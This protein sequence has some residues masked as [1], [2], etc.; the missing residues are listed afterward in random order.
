MKIYINDFTK[1]VKAE[2]LPVNTPTLD[3]TLET[4]S[5]ALLSTKK[6]LSASKIAPMQKVKVEF[7]NTTNDVAYFY[8]ISD[9][10]EIFSTNPVRYKHTISCI[11]NTRELSKHSVRNSVFTQPAY[12]YKKSMTPIIECSY[13]PDAQYPIAA[14]ELAT[15][16][17]AYVADKGTTLGITTREKVKKAYIEIDVQAA[18]RY[19]NNGIETKKW[20]YPTDLTDLNDELPQNLSQNSIYLNDD[21]TNTHVLITPADLGLS[22]WEFNKKIECPLVKEYIEDGK[23]D[24]YLS[25]AGVGQN[26]TI[27]FTGGNFASSGTVPLFIAVQMRI[28]VETY[29][30]DCYNILNLLIER[31]K[32]ENDINTN[33]TPLFSLPSD[34]NDSL[35][36]L[37]K[38]TVAPNFYFTQ[39]TLYECVAEVFRLF[40]AIFNMDENGVLGIEYFNDLSGEVITP[41]LVGKNETISED[42][43]TNG[44][45]AY[46]QDARPEQT[47]PSNNAYTGVRGSQLGV[48]LKE[49]RYFILGHKISSIIEL[50]TKI[51]GLTVFHYLSG[52]KL[53]SAI[54]GDYVI[55]LTDWV[56]TE[57][58]WTQLDVDNDDG[59][60]NPR[61]LIQANTLHFAEGDNKIAIGALYQKTTLTIDW[62]TVYYSFWN[63][64]NCAICGQFGIKHDGADLPD[65]S[66]PQ[67]DKFKDI[68]LQATYYSIVDGRTKVE[69]LI[70]KYD[71]ETLIDQYNGAVDLNKMGLNMLGLS[72][73]LGEPT[74]NAAHIISTWDKRIKTGQIYNYEGATWIA[75]VCSYTLLGNG[76]LKGQISFVKNFNQLALRTQLLREKRMSN[77]SHQLTIKSEDNYIDHVYFSSKEIAEWSDSGNPRLI[78]MAHNNT[79]R[80]YFYKALANT[81]KNVYD[82]ETIG[83]ATIS[84]DNDIKYT[85]SSNMGHGTIGPSGD[86]YQSIVTLTVNDINSR[87]NIEV[88]FTNNSGYPVST[89]YTT[90]RTSTTVIITLTC[91]TPNEDHYLE[92]FDDVNYT[93]NISNGYAQV[94]LPL[95]KYGAGNALCFEMAFENPMSAGNQT[96]SE[97]GWFG[98]DYYFT[99]AVKYTDADGFK[100]DF[101]IYLY[102]NK[103]YEFDQYFP[104]ISQNKIDPNDA[105]L[106]LENY[107]Y[108]KQPNEIFAINYELI[109]LPGDILND[110]I[111]SAFID[112]NFLVNNKTNE[113][114][115][116]YL[117]YSTSDDSKYSVLDIKG[118]G[119]ST[120]VTSLTAV[121]GRIDVYFS[122][123][124]DVKSWALCDENANIL[125]ASNNGWNGTNDHVSIYIYLSHDRLD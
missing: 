5:F 121:T 75:N 92:I 66:S 74:L 71:G 124:S 49:D 41:K 39:L 73:K 26:P 95:V 34:P 110:F 103:D 107:Y 123:L 76:Y 46:Y 125:F 100:D 50:K 102:L 85:N 63:C 62:S 82:I 16:T 12:K 70:N 113:N 59:T 99:T 108:Y 22:A 106:K 40:D 68:L 31:Q 27:L 53:E 38:N 4:F 122:S 35:Y 51:K 77:I 55:D 79:S 89:D 101:N 109:F 11:Q 36:K 58:L 111:G 10:V 1:P 105:Q 93:V 8:L 9:S 37:L 30:H 84:K 33:R 24:L 14:L 13:L 60:E 119:N 67:E 61:K 6:S 88:I 112:D 54:D 7:E 81:F 18:I 96:T 115:N 91:T 17:P 65:Y 64:L 56:V 19:I 104:Q 86:E 43:Y 83:I 25:T 120:P 48:P 97:T 87:D 114:K 23:L 116:C 32:Q 42:K 45:V 15:D 29:Y 47:F 52:S 44:L 57:D 28:V 80:T 20:F 98:N 69:S 72:L 118:E 90:S 94:Y 2:I 3:E 78:G 117:Y 21:D